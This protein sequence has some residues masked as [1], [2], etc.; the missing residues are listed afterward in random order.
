MKVESLKDLKKL[1]KVCQDTGVT[2]IE[3][4]GIKLNLALKPKANGNA[5]DAFPEASVRVPSYTPIQAQESQ[6]EAITTFNH[7][8]DEPD[9]LSEEEL[10]YYSVKPEPGQETKQWK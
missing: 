9:D 4:D 7:G 3:V 1:L 2:G 10:L 6:D 8:I 5:L